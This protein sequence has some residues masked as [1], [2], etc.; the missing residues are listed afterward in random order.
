M[1]NL[2]QVNK[3]QKEVNKAAGNSKR[4]YNE[5]YAESVE[6]KVKNLKH[7]WEEL[8]QSLIS[9]DALKI[10]LQNRNKIGRSIRCLNSFKQRNKSK[11]TSVI[12]NNYIN[13]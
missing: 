6:A 3:L 13:R 10:I 2:E 7:A 12:T 9:S 11:F 5:D 4:K 8:Y 1:D